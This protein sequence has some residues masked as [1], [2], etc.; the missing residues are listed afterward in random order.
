MAE[1]ITSS[2]YAKIKLA[3]ALS[4]RAKERREAG[5]FLAEGVRLLEEALE[6]GEGARS[7]DV[8]PADFSVLVL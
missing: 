7:A 6:A 4:G 5:A 1:I 8:R 2:Q 3:R